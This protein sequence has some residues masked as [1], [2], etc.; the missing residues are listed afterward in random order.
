MADED[1]FLTHKF[2]CLKIISVFFRYFV[3]NTWVFVTDPALSLSFLRAV[4]VHLYL[5]PA[6]EATVLALLLPGKTLSSTFSNTCVSPP[7]WCF[8]GSSCWGLCKGGFWLKQLHSHTSHLL[9]LLLNNLQWASDSTSKTTFHKTLIWHFSLS[10]R[11]FVDL[12][13][14]ITSPSSSSTSSSLS[15]VCSWISLGCLPLTTF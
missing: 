11:F 9:L 15:S 14:R 7:W 3:N 10:S 12:K 2:L 4:P 1:S 5:Q 6:S 8:G 13:S